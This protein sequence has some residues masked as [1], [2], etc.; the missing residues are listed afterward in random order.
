LNEKQLDDHLEIMILPFGRGFAVNRGKP[1][2][3]PAAPLQ[4][5]YFICPCAILTLEHPYWIH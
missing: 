1:C 5:V 4:L 2:E 3:R